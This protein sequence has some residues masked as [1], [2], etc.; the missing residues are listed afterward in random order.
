MHT[1][2]HLKLAKCVIN[3]TYLHPTPS[4]GEDE[5]LIALDDTCWLHRI[6]ELLQTSSEV[7]RKLDQEL[8]S[9]LVSYDCGWDRTT[10][11][12]MSLLVTAP[13]VS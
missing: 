7:C 6:Q 2:I 9:V 5:F 1:L 13:A 3:I 12:R 10:Q 4:R 8:A 11:V